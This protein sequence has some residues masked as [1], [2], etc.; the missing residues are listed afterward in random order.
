M[1]AS[2]QFRPQNR[3]LG[4]VMREV[5]E[6]LAIFLGI[7]NVEM[8]KNDHLLVEESHQ[9]DDELKCAKTCLVG[10]DDNFLNLEMEMRD[11]DWLF[12]QPDTLLLPSLDADVQVSAAS[13]TKGSKGEGEIPWK[14]ELDVAITASVIESSS[15]LASVECCTAVSRRPSPSSSARRASTPTGRPSAKSR[16]SRASTP[17]SRAALLPSSKPAAAQARSSTPVRPTSRSSTPASRP[18][19]PVVSKSE[20]RSATPTRKPVTPSTTSA[21]DRSSSGKKIVST[22]LKSSVPSRGASPVVKSRPSKP[23]DLLSSSQDT[24]QNM[25]VSSAPKRPASASRGR[26]SSHSTSSNEKPRQKS[27]S[28]ARVR[29]PVSSAAHRTGSSKVMS[30]S[31]GYSNGGDDVNPVVMGTKMVDRVVNMR[32][33]A[34]P[35]QDEYASQEN[36]RKSSQENSGFGRSLSKKSLEMAIRHMDIRRS[37]PNKSQTSA[38]CSARGI[39][40]GCA[41]IS[42]SA[43]PE[44][45]QTSNSDSWKSSSCRSSYFL[46]GAETDD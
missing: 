10:A 43:A 32:K 30:R 28:P 33:L 18:S 23:S 27:C 5:D 25:K 22:V 42:T 24:D 16:P 38:A 4:M 41:K 35:K 14:S 26:V 44:S 8:E 31:R 13:Q 1:A 37:V 40:S 6:D 12:K 34:P 15:T 45:P 20:T 2:V 19:I 29:A 36:S 3:D 21:S 39:Q 17:T 9:F 11:H 7:R 46:N